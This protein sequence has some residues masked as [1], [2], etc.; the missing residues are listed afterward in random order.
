MQGGAGDVA[1]T[2]FICFLV[3]LAIL[4]V[5]SILFLLTLYHTQKQVREPNRELSPALVWLTLIPLFG[6]IWAAIMVPK[7][8]NSL[9]REF[10]DRGWGTDGEGF[11][12]VPGMFW[13]WGGIANLVL[14]V[15]QN[16][17]RFADLGPIAFLLS[18][19]GLPLGLAVL[20]CWIIYWVQMYKYGKRLREGQ[21][22]YPEGSLEADYDEDFRQPRPEQEHYGHP[23]R[24][25]DERSD[26]PRRP[27][28]QD[29]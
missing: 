11:G 6:S 28:R 29:Y 21:P 7:L 19:L 24:D 18:L 27:D 2:A 23:R 15:L 8:T 22:E 20:A 17:L 5:L 4:L 16:V 12:Y 13:A 10:E 3:F 14:S 26:E 9:R 25:G 1:A